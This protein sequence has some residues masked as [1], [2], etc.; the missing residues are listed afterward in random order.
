[1]SKKRRKQP[2]HFCWCCQ[3]RRANE[4]FS[5]GGHARHIC[6]DCAKRGIAELAY[7]QAVRNVDRLLTWDGLIRRR[8]RQAFERFLNH[9][10]ERIR[11]YAQRVAAQA[12][13]ERSRRRDERMLACEEDERCSAELD[14][15][16]DV[17]DVGRQDEGA[18]EVNLADEADSI[19]F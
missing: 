2:G 12:E 10:N 13:Q 17:K 6:R 3:R 1:M 8:Q 7:R 16:G 5:G 19:P 11:S 18:A 15:S 14:E 4:R 9:S